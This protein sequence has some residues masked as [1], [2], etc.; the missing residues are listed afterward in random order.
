[1]VNGA[2]SAALGSL[3]VIVVRDNPGPLGISIGATLG[4]ASAFWICGALRK[5]VGAIRDLQSGIDLLPPVTAV[6]NRDTAARPLGIESER[7]YG[8]DGHDD[9]RK[10][11]VDLAWR[12]EGDSRDEW[13]IKRTVVDGHVPGNQ[14]S[15]LLGDLKV[16]DPSGSRSRVDAIGRAHS[17]VNT[18]EARSVPLGRTP[19]P[20]TRPALAAAAVGLSIVVGGVVIPVT[21]SS[22]QLPSITSATDDSA[23]GGGESV[24]IGEA[25]DMFLALLD[26]ADEFKPG[27][28]QHVRSLRVTPGSG[29]YGTFHDPETGQDISVNSFDL[30][31][32]YD[33]ELA[34]SDG[35][36]SLA[37]RNLPDFAAMSQTI[38]ADAG[39]GE[40]T[41]IQIA[42]VDTDAPAPSQA[43]IEFQYGEGGNYTYV[44]GRLD[45]TLA[46]LWA[47]DDM[48]AW[49]EQLGAT[50]D[51][52]GYAPFDLG[53]IL[54]KNGHEFGFDV[55]RSRGGSFASSL[56]GAGTGFAI[57]M[58]VGG[59][60]I[61]LEQPYGGFATT[62]DPIV[63]STP[64]LT[65]ALSEV[66]GDALQQV[67]DASDAATNAEPIDK[68]NRYVQVSRGISDEE[69]TQLTDAGQD[70]Y[71]VDVPLRYL[72]GYGDEDGTIYDADGTPSDGI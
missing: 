2:A 42:A 71:E 12:A 39:L 52:L 66:S 49:Y 64:P 69:N 3:A 57:D 63:S 55:L 4:V 29:A 37:D 34:S 46:P 61:R 72:V 44:H 36:F 30:T 51:E 23:T 38:D 27:S 5:S 50:L 26:A 1:M 47:L 53:A 8:P 70:P 45:G 24:T 11:S 6:G 19:R 68:A 18:E 14:L 35:T 15:S 28:S 62:N 17:R 31:P 25:T 32:T 65:F 43:E 21:M 33:D 48:D 13:I 41:D 59:N 40:P 58:V 60:M 54:I 67:I 9:R 7:T 16:T 20:R 56:S 10:V 22:A